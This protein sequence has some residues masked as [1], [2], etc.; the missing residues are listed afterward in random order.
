MET[1]G[2]SNFE[3]PFEFV[4][5]HQQTSASAL[6]VRGRSKSTFVERGRR[7]VIEKRTKT[8]RRRGGPSVCVR[9][10]F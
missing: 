7:G 3:F 8:N 9:S 5:G 2:C 10:L 4:P 6:P 1:N